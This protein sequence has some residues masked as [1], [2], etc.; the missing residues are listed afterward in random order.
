[1]CEAIVALIERE[2][3]VREF[4]EAHRVRVGGKIIDQ[5]LE[6]LHVAVAFRKREGANLAATLKN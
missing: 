1:M 3:E 2:T 5:H 4:F 6:R